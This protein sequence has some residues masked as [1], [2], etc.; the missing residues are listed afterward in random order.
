MPRFNLAMKDSPREEVLL[1]LGTAFMRT[2]DSLQPKSRQVRVTGSIL[3]AL[4]K[5]N[6]LDPAATALKDEPEHIPELRE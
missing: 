6:L 4:Q 1:S 2:L 3:R 5:R